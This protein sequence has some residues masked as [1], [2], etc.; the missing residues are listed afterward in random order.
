MNENSLLIDWLIDWLINLL[1]GG[2]FVLEERPLEEVFVLN[3]YDQ[4]SV[5][6]YLS[7]QLTDPKEIIISQILGQ[8]YVE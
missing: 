1:P 4:H 3:D 5:E 7:H 8:V 2:R 6:L